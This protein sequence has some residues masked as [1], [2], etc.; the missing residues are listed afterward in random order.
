MVTQAQVNFDKFDPASEKWEFYNERLENYLKISKTTDDIKSS[1]LVNCLDAETYKV[2]RDICTPVLPITLT[3][4]EL[5]EI[6]SKHFTK[7]HLVHKERRSFY[8]ATRDANEDVNAWLARIKSLSSN[9]KFG[10]QLDLLLT[11]KFIYGTRG[12]AFERICEEN[13]TIT[14]AKAHDLAMKYDIESDSQVET[15]IMYVSKGSEKAHAARYENT[16]FSGSK[17]TDKKKIVYL[18]R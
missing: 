16:K 11:D 15:D 14:L 4:K 6:M 12:K 9:C 2:V 18:L 17:S 3:Y 13:E 7:P 1:M 10:A 5:C 8:E